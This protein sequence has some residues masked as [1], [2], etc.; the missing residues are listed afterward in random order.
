MLDY[1]VIENF[2][3]S[4]HS[5]SFDWPLCFGEVS[6]EKSSVA[7][8]YIRKRK[9]MN[10]ENFSLTKLCAMLI[11]KCFGLCCYYVMLLFGV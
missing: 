3:S 9:N 8:L 10:C 5:S 4:I 7:M 1:I 6:I 11:L 2:G